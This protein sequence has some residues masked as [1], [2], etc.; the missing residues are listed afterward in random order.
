[1]GG[2]I[3]TEHLLR[4]F[5]AKQFA[6][7]KVVLDIA[8][9]EGYGS[10]FLSTAA[11]RV[12]GVDVS[13]AAIRYAR[14]RYV[15]SP[16]LE[17]EVG[18]IQKLAFPDATFDLITCFE[19]VEHVQEPARA[20]QEL[21]RILKPSGTLLISTPNP[22]RYTREFDYH[23]PFH[24]N[25]LELDAFESV[26][27]SYF[28]SVRLLGQTSASAS[29]IAPLTDLSSIALESTS[30]RLRVADIEA[31]TGRAHPKPSAPI[32][33]LAV[34][35]GDFANIDEEIICADFSDGGA[36]EDEFLLRRVLADAAASEDEKQVLRRTLNNI[37]HEHAVTLEQLEQ[38]RK[39][40]ALA[41]KEAALAT[42]K[43]QALEGSTSWRAL[44]RVRR[45]LSRLPLLR[46]V[47][48]R[49]ALAF[50]SAGELK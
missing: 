20:I 3:A 47:I 42:E 13:E 8:S 48:R 11:R 9:G 1:M 38:S 31:L 50:S 4:Y 40:A 36:I 10:A 6:H 43:L 35:G 18:D 7:Q 30:P 22:E 44:G 45:I 19:T 26:L 32:Y 46:K 41:R 21:R 12:V 49:I 34:C 29:V 14:H 25:E 28:E 27:R 24:I 5:F 15:D 16:N 37:M 2:R 17:F 39:E 23:N 33:Y